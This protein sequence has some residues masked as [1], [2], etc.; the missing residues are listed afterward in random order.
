MLAITSKSIRVL[1][2]GPISGKSE[3]WLFK[4]FNFNPPFDEDSVKPIRSNSFVSAN[5][6]LSRGRLLGL[7]ASISAWA[8]SAAPERVP[9]HWNLQGEV[10]GYGS[11]A[12]GLLFL[13][14]LVRPQGLFGKVLERKA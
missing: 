13:I 9:I 14:L 5:S 6:S 8:W 11:K 12:F 1:K 2:A 7:M 10:D 3:S 4:L